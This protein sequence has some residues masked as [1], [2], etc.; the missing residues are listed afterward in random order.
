MSEKLW[1]D[2]G[3]VLEGWEL[4]EDGWYLLEKDGSAVRVL[5]YFKIR[6]HYI[7]GQGFG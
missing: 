5:P 2:E 6:A 4:R 1:V 3:L 7:V